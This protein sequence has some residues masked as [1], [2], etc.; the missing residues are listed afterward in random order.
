MF[1][2]STGSSDACPTCLCAEESG[3]GGAITYLDVFSAI[4]TS[5]L[6][7]L[8][9]HQRASTVQNEA[10]AIESGQDAFA[11]ARQALGRR[12]RGFGFRIVPGASE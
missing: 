9:T 11:T 8:E 3:L 2:L 1:R 7:E 10:R 5:V 4:W 12:P 6:S